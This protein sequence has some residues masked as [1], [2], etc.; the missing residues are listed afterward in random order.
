[1]DLK[2]LD[3]EDWRCVEFFRSCFKYGV[4]NITTDETV[5]LQYWLAC[6]A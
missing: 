6:Y 2:E 5:L 3:C 1:M 4:R